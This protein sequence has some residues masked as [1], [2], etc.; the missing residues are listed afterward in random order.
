MKLL[1]KCLTTTVIGLLRIMLGFYFRRVELFHAERV[2]SNGPVLFASNHPGSVT[3]AFIIGTSVPRQVHFV[4]TVQLFRF[5]PLAWLLKQCGIIPINRLKDD[6]RAMRS[7]AATFEA[8]FEVLEEGGAVGIFPEGVSYDDS[9]LKTIK[10]GA[11][12]MALELEHRHGGKLGLRII[13]VGLTYSAKERYRSEVL[14]HFGEPI[15]AAKFLEGY[16]ARRK[17][18]ITQ[19]SGEIERRLQLL[20]VHLPGLEQARVVEAMKRLYLERL[21]LGN[22]IVKEPLTPRAEDLVLS[23]AIA[24]AAEWMER[25]FPERFNAFARKLRDYERRRARLKLSDETNERLSEKRNLLAYGLS[26]ALLVV[27]GAPIAVYGWVH[28][29]LPFALISL[30]A[31]RFTNP[32]ARKA[33]KPHVS[34]LVGVFAFGGCY[35]LYVWLVHRWFGWPFSLWYAL[36]LPIA[37]LI[38]YYYTHEMLRLCDALR[39]AVILFRVPF[40]RKRLLSLRSELLAEIEEARKEYRRSVHFTETA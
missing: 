35:A 11:A 36:S 10:T 23:Q 4:A 16:D 2:P 15:E 33:Q 8:C 12:R 38:S 25:T 7:V 28:R 6:P 40:A 3:D 31:T 29:L 32:G 18:C 30:V 5:A 24:N 26:R 37:G 13:P 27:L 22:I 19:L 39:T 17:E 34:M 21:K 20:I 9:Q 14:V 1:G